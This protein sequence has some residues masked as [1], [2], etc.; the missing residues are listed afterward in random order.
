MAYG[1]SHGG[2]D[3]SRTWTRDASRQPSDHT[4][5]YTGTFGGPGAGARG[6]AAAGPVLKAGAEKFKIVRGPDDAGATANCMP[7]VPP[8]SWG[9]PYQFQIL[10]A[11]NYVA[12]FHEYP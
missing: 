8:Q 11:A 3:R 12:I 4:G 9:V 7:L 1:K 10:Q 2:D 6:G 5:V